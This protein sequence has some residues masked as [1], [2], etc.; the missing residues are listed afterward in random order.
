M[1]IYVLHINH[2]FCKSSPNFDKEIIEI[3][4]KVL[5][6]SWP[7]I[8]KHV[9]HIFN[10]SLEE[11]VFPTAWKDF[12]ILPYNKVSNPQQASDYRP[13]ALL[14]M[15]SKIFEKCVSYQ[16]IKYFEVNSILDPSQSGFRKGASTQTVLAKLADDVR[17]GF[18]EK[19]YTFLVLFDFTKA[20]DRVKHKLL[21]QK[22]Q[23]YGFDEKSLRWFESYLHNRRQSVLGD[24][25]RS[26]WRQ[27]ENGVP[28]G[29]VLGPLLFI[30]YLNDLCLKIP[31]T[32]K[33]IYADDLQ[34]YLQFSLQE[35]QNAIQTL[36]NI[37]EVI[38]EWCTDNH[39]AVNL[40]KTASMLF[41]TDNM[42]KKIE[43]LVPEKLNVS[44][45]SIAVV[46]VAKSLGMLIDSN[47]S[48]S[49]HIKK[50]TATINSVLYHL[51]LFKGY[52]T[53][54]LRTHLVSALALP[55]L[56][57]GAAVLG[58]LNGSQDSLLQKSLN[59]CVRYVFNLNSRERVSSKRRELG[60]LSSRNRRVYLSV[61]LL[62]KVLITGK[63]EYINESLVYAHRIRGSRRN[64]PGCQSYWKKS[65]TNTRW[66]G[67]T[68]FSSCHDNPSTKSWKEIQT[69]HSRNKMISNC[70]WKLRI[71]IVCGENLIFFEDQENQYIYV[72]ILKGK[73]NILLKCLYFL[74]VVT[75]FH[76]FSPRPKVM[77]IFYE[78][79]TYTSQ[80]IHIRELLLV[81]WKNKFL[82]L[83]LIYV[84]PTPKSLPIYSHY[85]PFK[86]VFYESYLKRNSTLFPD[87]LKD[88]KGYIFRVM[89][90][91]RQIPDI[92]LPKNRLKSESYLY[93]GQWWLRETTFI[94]KIY[95]ARFTIAPRQFAGINS[96]TTIG[97]GNTIFRKFW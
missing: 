59:K 83:T 70:W 36:I 75:W 44:S 93:L 40:Q 61:T 89:D 21:L 45:G 81:S 66:F 55:I 88:M 80:K 34:V 43:T 8:Q 97:N 60:W 67:L 12:Y 10:T 94:L 95:F 30:V 68:I 32:L 9:L 84:Q 42:L 24:G 54:E 39:L 23:R 56:D 7:A 87:K 53:V 29:S 20:F 41:G 69:V 11:E 64:Y 63:P 82:D 22:L 5:R 38:F 31:N 2:V 48:W 72:I 79:T 26:E 25:T 71:P 28:Q 47:L 18:S 92:S 77:I 16:L 76:H 15:L 27:V 96:R 78:N 19:L 37:T 65:E 17:R 91:S 3:S 57:Y 62:H 90:L 74:R 6:L 4:L 52:T 49:S 86:R 50:V 46:K 85:Q 58:D 14:C 51:R 73:K 35:F 33:L 1:H 13:V